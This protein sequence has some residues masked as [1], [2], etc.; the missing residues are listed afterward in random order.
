MGAVAV[1]DV[2]EVEE[3]ERDKLCCSQLNKC[4]LTKKSSLEKCCLSSW[5]IS[6]TAA[7]EIVQKSFAIYSKQSTAL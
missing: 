5:L 7:F 3:G 6:D 2:A 1:E 4:I